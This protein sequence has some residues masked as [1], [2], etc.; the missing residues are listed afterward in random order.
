MIP[1]SKEKNTP[2]SFSQ[3]DEL[4]IKQKYQIAATALGED[5]SFGLKTFGD[6]P[7]KIDPLFSRS[8]SETRQKLKKQKPKVYKDLFSNGE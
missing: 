8:F 1:G 5:P 7:N 3:K 6:D 4:T 2:G